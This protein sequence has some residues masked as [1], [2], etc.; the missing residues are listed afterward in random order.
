MF[1]LLPLVVG[2]CSVFRSD[3]FVRPCSELLLVS[4]LMSES[5]SGEHDEES[6]SKFEWLRRWCSP[7]L[8]DELLLEPPD[9]LFAAE[10][11][12]EP[13]FDFSC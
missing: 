13:C 2:E 10:L 5:S 9:E 8:A 1:G 12:L 11:D 6:S 3:R 7:E 4:L